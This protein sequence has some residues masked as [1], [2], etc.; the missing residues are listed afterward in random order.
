MVSGSQRSAFALSLRQVFWAT[1]TLA[2]FLS[3]SFD[4]LTTALVMGTVAIT[5]GRGS[6]KFIGP[7]CISV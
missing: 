6:P 7:A 2:F 3:S 5:V 4:N 1:G